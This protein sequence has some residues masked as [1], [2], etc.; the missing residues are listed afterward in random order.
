MPHLEKAKLCPM[1]RDKDEPTRDDAEFSVQF[2]PSS[3]HLVL[4]SVSDASKTPARQ[5]EQHLGSGNLTLSLD[6]HFDTADE[7]Q[8]G[9]PND[10]RGRTKQVAQFMLPSQGSSDPPPRVRFAWGHFVVIGVMATYN[11]DI[12]L[13]SPEGAPLR[14]KVSISV[15]GRH[16]R[17]RRVALGRRAR[18][19]ERGR[20]ARGGARRLEQR[21]HRGGDR[22]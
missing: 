19:T 8:T 1:K 6:L 7:G 5:A 18:R 3:M 9:A 4:Q 14:A 10:V 15:R 17:V 2:N 20:V 16:G 13:F 11:E 12:D 21:P 22:R